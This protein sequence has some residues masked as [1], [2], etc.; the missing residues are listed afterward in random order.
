MQPKIVVVMGAEALAA[1]GEMDIPLARPLQRAAR[2]GPAADADDRRAVRART[3]TSRSTSRTP[4]ASSGPP[5][6]CSASGTRRSRPTERRPAGCQAVQHDLA[7]LAA[8]GEALVGRGGLAPAGRSRRPARAA[9]R[10]SNSGSTSCSRRRAASAFSSSGRARSVEPWMR[11]RL[12]ISASRFSSPL[13]PAETPITAIRPP[14]ASACR[15][16]AM[17]GAP[18]SSRITSNGP[19]ARRSPRARSRS[20]RAPRPARA[21][22]RCARSR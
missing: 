3:S 4:S 5:S 11:A 8:G 21:A 13:A 12:P 7:E 16:S 18:T 19:A 10:A 22:P 20:R 2:R 14:V 9:R 6:A 15:F 1:L 17:L